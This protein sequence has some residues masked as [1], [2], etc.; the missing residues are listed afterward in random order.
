MKEKLITYKHSQI[1]YFEFGNGNKIILCFHGYGESAESFLFLETLLAK[2]F[3]IISIDA[4]F[5]GK[6]LW[7]EGLNFTCGDL[8]EIISLITPKN[9]QPFYLLGYS[10]GGR[11]ALSLLQAMPSQI[12]RIVLLATDGLHKNFWY[13]FSTQTFIG[14]KIFAFTMKYPKA[15]FLLLKLAGKLKLINNS[16]D[17]VTH[18]YVDDATERKL[19]YERWITMRKFKPDA[20]KIALLI[21]QNKIAARF[22]F[23]KHDKIILSKRSAVFKNDVENVKVELLDAGH[24]LLKEKYAADIVKQFY[25]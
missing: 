10:M 11:I 17:K 23:G 14:Q 20:G 18:Y 4:P 15:F 13:W 8:R 9:E 1:S 3:R 16:I 7:H 22:L 24:Q 19:L 2:D 21:N 5:H 6:T 12:E 25:Q